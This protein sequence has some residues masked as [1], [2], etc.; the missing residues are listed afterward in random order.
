MLKKNKT[1]IKD[2]DEDQRAAIKAAAKIFYEGGTFIYPTDTIYGLGANPFNN[3][4]MT[5]LSKI[6]ERPVNKQYIML[7][8]DLESL[9]RY[10]NF[11]NE[12]HLDFLRKIWPNPVSVVLTLNEYYQSILNAK[13]VA[14][15]IPDNTFCRKLLDEINM[16]LVSTS[17]N[18]ANEEP[19]N[20]YNDLIQKY[21]YEVDAIFY[22][23]KGIMPV[24]STLIDLSSDHLFLVREGKMKFKYLTKQFDSI[25]NKISAE[26]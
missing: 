10:V 1:L 13:T 15:R 14:F 4:A 5:K 17:A 22:T 20:E 3:D 12:L 24:S 6:K 11:A 26:D 8:G 18:R 19:V 9:M 16:P 25:V 7:I 2:I 23:K 21:K